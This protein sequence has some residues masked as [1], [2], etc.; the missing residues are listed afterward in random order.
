M[1]FLTGRNFMHEM[2]IYGYDDEIQ[3]FLCADFMLGENGKFTFKNVSYKDIVD[4]YLKS[5]DAD[6][7]LYRGRGGLQM[8]SHFDKRE[9]TFSILQFITSINDYLTEKN[10]FDYIWNDEN[11][12]DD[13]RF[14]MSV[15]SEMLRRIRDESTS[16]DIRVLSN[17]SDHKKMLYHR[18]LY[19]KDRL[20]LKITRD[21]GFER[22]YTISQSVLSRKIKEHIS[23]KL[24]TD[25]IKDSL[26]AMQKIEYDAL[27]FL[28]D[29][30]ITLM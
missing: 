24:Y 20:K 7:F 10:M 12:R 30:L 28:R 8:L 4:A 25:N 27:S 19:F 29:D 26:T 18:E 1:S 15:Y 14:G 5:S 11:S 6:D 13:Y 22:L 3:S 2:C 21:Y 9:Y 17:L 16:I 23:G